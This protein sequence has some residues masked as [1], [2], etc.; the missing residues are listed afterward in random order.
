M[1][2]LAAIVMVM[3]VAWIASGAAL[4]ALA[5]L[6]PATWSLTLRLTLLLVAAAVAVLFTVALF[7]IGLPAAAAAVAAALVVFLGLRRG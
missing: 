3:F 1:E 5:W 4:V 2:D 6:A 7:G